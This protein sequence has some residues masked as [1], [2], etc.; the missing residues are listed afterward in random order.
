LNRA[1]GLLGRT[2]FF[3]PALLVVLF[4]PWIAAAWFLTSAAV[5]P[6]SA[7]VV[8]KGGAT[9]LLV[10]AAGLLVAAPAAFVAA[11][12]VF[13]FPASPSAKATR[14]VVD[15]LAGLPT[16]LFGAVAASLAMRYS[17]AVDQRSY[18]GLIL[19][20][21]PCGFALLPRLFRAFLRAFSR[22]PFGYRE[23]ALALGVSR[24]KTLLFVVAKSSRRDLLAGVFV[25]AA[26]GL[27]EVGPLLF[28]GAGASPLPLQVLQGGFEN[29][30]GSTVFACLVLLL[31]ISC[32]Q[33]LAALTQRAADRSHRRFGPGFP[34]AALSPKAKEPSP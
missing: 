24:A 20:I 16:L 14:W 5:T 9:S 1:T 23:A 26:H 33:L 11:A 18:M 4:A 29:N 10:T 21:F 8:L 31:A 22:V 12:L 13:E 7:H 28:L 30:R 17:I 2:G 32:F 3:V 19:A 6:S 34:P 25:A 27:G 15:V